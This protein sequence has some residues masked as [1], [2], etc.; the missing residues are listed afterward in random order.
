VSAS[1]EVRRHPK[2]KGPET[3]AADASKPMGSGGD[4]RQQR[5]HRP[6][7]GA[8]CTSQST[9][10]RNYY[11]ILLFTTV[12]RSWNLHYPFFI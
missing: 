3:H 7:L 6:V 4:R 10:E 1:S 11:L 9:D 12:F 2:G 8:R 5:A